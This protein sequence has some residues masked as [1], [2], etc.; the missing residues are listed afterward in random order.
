MRP[1]EIRRSSFPALLD[2]RKSTYLVDAR[3]VVHDCRLR[4][5]RLSAAETSRSEKHEQHGRSAIGP[6]ALL[7]PYV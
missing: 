2:T 5:K 1:K 4:P 7:M 3:D 6:V